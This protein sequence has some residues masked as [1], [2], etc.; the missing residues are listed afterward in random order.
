MLHFTWASSFLM[1]SPEPLGLHVPSHLTTS[2]GARGDTMS[3][4][5]NGPV[6]DGDAAVFDGDAA[7]LLGEGAV[8]DG[9]AAPS[10]TLGD[11]S[12]VTWWALGHLPKPRYSAANG[13][14]VLFEVTQKRNCEACSRVLRLGLLQLVQTPLDSRGKTMKQASVASPLSPLASLI[15]CRLAW[16]SQNSGYSTV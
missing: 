6:L 3:G 1:K 12:Q 14:Y 2:A 8:L 9:E 16:H 10:D 5:G 7:V 15:D 11:A 13:N 4:A